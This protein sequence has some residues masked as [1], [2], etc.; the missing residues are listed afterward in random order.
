MPILLL[1]IAPYAIL[2]GMLL[3]IPL[4]VL[5]EAENDVKASK[6][7]ERDALVMYAA[8][9]EDQAEARKKLWAYKQQLKVRK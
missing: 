5:G 2:A 8:C 9:A 1:F 4:Y 3:G 7:R 6:L